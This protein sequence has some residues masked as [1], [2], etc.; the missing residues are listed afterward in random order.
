MGGGVKISCRVSKNHGKNKRLPLI[1]LDLRVHTI[2]ME[3]LQ[4]VLQVVS[5][6]SFL[7]K[8][9]GNYKTTEKEDNVIFINTWKD[10]SDCQPDKIEI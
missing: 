9:Q 1:Y 7:W 10:I 2:L 5:S 3:Y 8:L 4:T 6:F